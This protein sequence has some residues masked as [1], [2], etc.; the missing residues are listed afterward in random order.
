MSESIR[1]RPRWIE[2]LSPADHTEYNDLFSTIPDCKGVH[3]ASEKF[4]DCI[5]AIKAFV[6][7]PNGDS[8]RRGL[9]CGILWLD[10]VVITNTAQLRCLTN[11]GKSSVNGF[12]ARQ[13][14]KVCSDVEKSKLRSKLPKEI[15]N[16]PQELRKWTMRSLDAEPSPPPD[17]LPDA[18]AGC[19]LTVD[20]GSS[21][22]Q[23]FP[24]FDDDPGE[25][26]SPMLFDY[27]EEDIKSP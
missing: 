2:L 6:M 5:C 11:R 26:H 16:D 18:T 9:V 3:G 22:G 15:A 20:E 13:G 19:P 4:G 23:G 8:A 17:I 24:S 21:S 10:K 27:S 12:F 1:G 25:Q 7:H 14:Y